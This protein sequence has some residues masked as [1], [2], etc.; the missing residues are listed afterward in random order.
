M[1]Q[2]R[3]LNGVYNIFSKLKE[4]LYHINEIKIDYVQ[5]SNLISFEDYS[6]LYIK[7]HYEFIRK[8]SLYKILKSKNFTESQFLYY[9]GK[10]YPHFLNTA[11]QLFPNK[12]ETIDYFMTKLN[13]TRK[14]LNAIF[15]NDN[16]IL[17]DNIAKYVKK[18]YM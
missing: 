18:L 11:K 12:E 2:Y 14:K 15:E 3:K 13:E 4:K 10:K 9:V 8:Y 17:D 5:S 1:N 7:L 16:N 6:K